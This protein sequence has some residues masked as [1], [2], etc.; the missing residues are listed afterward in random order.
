MDLFRQ[1]FDAQT[2]VGVNCAKYWLGVYG[3]TARGM[4]AAACE[5]PGTW[6]PT[7]RD[8]VRACREAHW[9]VPPGSPLAGAPV[10]IQ[11]V[12]HN[13]EIVATAA[14]IVAHRFGCH[15]PP[16]DSDTEH[17]LRAMHRIVVTLSSSARTT[18]PVFQLAAA[19]H[20]MYVIWNFHREALRVDLAALALREA[21]KAG[22]WEG[23]AVHRDVD[24][25]LRAGAKRSE[26]QWLLWCAAPERLQH[27]SATQVC[28]CMFVAA[29]GLALKASSDY[30][31]RGFLGSWARVAAG[32]APGA[33]TPARVLA[34]EPAIARTLEWRNVTRLPYVGFFHDRIHLMADALAH[35][36]TRRGMLPAA[37]VEPP[38]T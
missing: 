8:A 6:P 31:D 32:V 14:I 16:Q 30:P 13:R 17:I 38:A 37:P 18:L 27:L 5:H 23:A 28:V 19:L 26:P 15:A 12:A 33:V 3:A 29:I 35:P 11:S 1:H 34:L 20:V 25:W 4:A 24:A 22:Y 2:R 21:H 10:S 9:A 36:S 7:S